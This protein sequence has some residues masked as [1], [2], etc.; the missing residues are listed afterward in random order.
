VPVSNAAL[1][2][3]ISGGGEPALAKEWL[4]IFTCIGTNGTPCG[5]TFATLEEFYAHRE[6]YNNLFDTFQIS[7]E[8]ANCHAGYYGEEG[9]R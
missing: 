8:E 3:R 4:S 7:A 2:Q 5:A 6:Y 9:Y 1:A